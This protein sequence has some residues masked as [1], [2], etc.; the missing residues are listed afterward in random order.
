MVVA[1][2]SFCTEPRPLPMRHSHTGMRCTQTHSKY[3]VDSVWEN[4]Y[5]LSIFIYEI[6][7][8]R[9]EMLTSQP[10]SQSAKTL[11]VRIMHA[12]VYK[13]HQTSVQFI[14]L[15]SQR[16]KA[17][18]LKW[19]SIQFAE[20]VPFRKWENQQ[21]SRAKRSGNSKKKICDENADKPQNW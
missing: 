1:G 7:V 20:K 15:S 21:W 5:Q 19:N 12:N 2:F 3:T 13:I 16:I 18:I 4:K 10:A 6:K 11:Y 8:L 17:L 14:F 9:L